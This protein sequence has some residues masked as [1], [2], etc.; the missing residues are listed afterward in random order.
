MRVCVR[1]NEVL[2]RTERAVIYSRLVEGRFPDYKVVLPKKHNIK[3][4]L[5]ASSFQAAVRQ[6]AI[7]TDEDS[8]KVTFRFDKGKLTLQAQGATAGRSKVELPIEYDHK[9]IAL[10]FNPQY[11]IEMLKVLPPDAELCVDLIDEKTPV[12]FHSGPNYKYLVMPLL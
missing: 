3:V 2:F 5:E 11:M 1:P 6:A 4:P 9:P 7:M 8:K 10:G 12:L